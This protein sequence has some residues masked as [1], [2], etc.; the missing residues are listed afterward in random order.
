MGHKARFY[1]RGSFTA[2]KKFRNAF[3]FTFCFAACLLSVERVSSQTTK[4][5]T[6]DD[7]F[8]DPSKPYVYLE[9]D[10]VG[11]RKPLRDGEPSKGI[12]LRLK[13]NCRFPVVVIASDGAGWVED[14]VVPNVPPTGTESMGDGIGEEPGQEDL[15]DIFYSPNVNE[16]EVRAA[17]SAAKT[18]QKGVKSEIEKRPH[19]YNDGYHL[20]SQ[21]LKVI[22]S[23]GEVLFSLPFNHVSPTWHIEIPF[24]FA[25]RHQGQARPPY[26]YVAFYWDD[27]PETY[28]STNSEPTVRKPS[29]PERAL[30]HE[31]SHVAPPEQH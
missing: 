13:N 29:S 26:S 1:E 27:L 19:G 24:R 10:R 2:M 25:F 23:G 15:T 6:K 22:P 9:V 18:S 8:L 17:E 30:A 31:S 12:W 5:A 3:L 11:P 16:A 4:Q 21:V 28:R 20:G 14:E 7:L